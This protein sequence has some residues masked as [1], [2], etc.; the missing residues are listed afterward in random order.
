MLG[1][2]APVE[3]RLG[4]PCQAARERRCRSRRDSALELRADCGSALVPRLGR[5]VEL[6]ERLVGACPPLLPPLGALSPSLPTH[7][8]HHQPPGVRRLI[9]PSSRSSYS[10]SQISPR[11]YR[12][13]ASTNC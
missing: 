8:P 9:S 2:A 4:G 13:S 3:D 10:S 11:S 5:G 1:P 7:L 6:L 12:A